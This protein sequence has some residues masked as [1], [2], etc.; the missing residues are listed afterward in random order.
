MCN[1]PIIATPSGDISDLLD[2]VEPSYLCPP[3]VD[4]LSDALIDC[5]SRRRRSNGHERKVAA[6]SS[7]VNTVRLLDIYERLGLPRSLVLA[8]SDKEP[9]A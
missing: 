1:L 9:S 2:G 6:L 7:E 5:L 4:V 3:E 8:E